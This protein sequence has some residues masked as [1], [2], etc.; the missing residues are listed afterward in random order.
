MKDVVKAKLM[1]RQQAEAQEQRNDAYS[2]LEALGML[3]A[4]E[5]SPP[6]RSSQV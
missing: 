3:A 1:S 4:P 5:Q 2:Y 6:F